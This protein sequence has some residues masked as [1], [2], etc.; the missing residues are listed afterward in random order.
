MVRQIGPEISMVTSQQRPSRS[1]VIDFLR[2]SGA[3][4]K[5]RTCDLLVRSQ[6]LYPTE[7][8]ARGEAEI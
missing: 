2:K 1:N 6:T 5:T 7:L 4:C 8:R 3:P